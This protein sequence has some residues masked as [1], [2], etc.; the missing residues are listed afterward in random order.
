MVA[1]SPY[2]TVYNYLSNRSGG[3]RALASVKA[4]LRAL[5][6][7]ILFSFTLSNARATPIAYPTLIPPILVQRETVTTPAD[8][9]LSPNVSRTITILI[10][11]AVVASFAASL[12]VFY[13]VVFAGSEDH[14]NGRDNGESRG[15]GVTASGTTGVVNGGNGSNGDRGN[16][17][18]APNLFGVVGRPGTHVA[19]RGRRNA[20]ANI[21]DGIDDRSSGSSG[22][23]EVGSLD[24]SILSV[25]IVSIII[26]SRH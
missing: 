15:A 18:S 16:A 4:Y 9:L 20:L 21:H 7:S 19:H 2:K 5:H 23:S 22:S 26:T 11:F 8:P 12:L 13:R 25:C 10:I 17:G 1:I 14:E 24:T 3:F 6:I